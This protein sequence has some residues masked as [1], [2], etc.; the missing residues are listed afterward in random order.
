MLCGTRQ[1]ESHLLKR[2]DIPA[3]VQS[4]HK[5]A[6]TILPKA[7]TTPP[8][9]L[10]PRPHLWLWPR[11][12]LLIMTSREKPLQPLLHSCAGSAPLVT[13]PGDE[14]VGVA[15]VDCRQVPE[16]D[17]DRLGRLAVGEEFSDGSIVRYVE[18]LLRVFPSEM[19]GDQRRVVYAEPQFAQFPSAAFCRSSGAM[20]W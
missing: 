4:I 15:D 1:I 10:L 14:S 3:L 16:R 2:G 7:V 6:D 19:F 9:D 17:W 5:E 13:A 12:P 18:E 20:Y 11:P 8:T